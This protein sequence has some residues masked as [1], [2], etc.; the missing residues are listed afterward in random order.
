MLLHCSSDSDG[1][2]VLTSNKNEL[3]VYVFETRGAYNCLLQPGVYAGIIC[4]FPQ[5]VRAIG[6]LTSIGRDA[7]V[8]FGEVI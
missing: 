5:I 3:A 2:G 6:V 8:R 7:C 1:C 4:T